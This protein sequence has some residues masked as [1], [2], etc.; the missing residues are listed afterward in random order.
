MILALKNTFRFLLLV[1][2]AVNSTGC[3]SLVAH[4]IARSPN[5]YPDWLA[6]EAPVTLAFNPKLLTNFAKQ[7]I[8]VQTP[9]AKLMYRV[10][11]PADYQLKATSTNWIEEGKPQYCFAFRAR[12]PALTNAWTL[13]PRGTVILLHGYGVAQFSLLPW[14]LTLAGDGW[15]CVLIDLRGHG[16]STGKQI[17]F[18]TQETDDLRKLLD[19]LGHCHKLTGPVSLVG[20][21]YGAVL[22]LRYEAVDPRI[23]AV[24][25]IAP[26]GSLSNA[27]LN[28]R[29]DYV[30]WFPEFLIKD[31]LIKLPQVLGVT[32]DDLDTT[33]IMKQ[34]PVSALF[35]AGGQDTIAPAKEVSDLES[36]ASPDS[37][38]FTVPSGTHEALPYFFDELGAPV[39]NWLPSQSR[40][41]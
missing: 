25:A 34:H 37:K 38:F 19:E 13:Q 26:Y 8:E 7:Y 29:R 24:V 22:A 20:E 3:G 10:I 21:S 14:A 35:I 4:L 16:K 5:R 32:P 30:G 40:K 2:V 17:Y 28:I 36:L 23:Q 18:G 39:E 33:T 9:P 31:G 41:P 11:E 12:M 1:M 27:V 15:R 6:P